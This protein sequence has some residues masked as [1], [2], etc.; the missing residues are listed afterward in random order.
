MAME[1]GLQTRFPFLALSTSGG[2]SLSWSSNGVAI[3]GISSASKLFEALFIEG[4]KPRVEAK[5]PNDI[6]D[7]L[8][9]IAKQR[10]LDDLIVLA[11]QTDSVRTNRPCLTA[12]R[13][14]SDRT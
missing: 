5:R 13:C 8:D 3:P 12:P 14:C 6:A 11:I 9:A 1:V 4:T 2:T 10:L 7:K